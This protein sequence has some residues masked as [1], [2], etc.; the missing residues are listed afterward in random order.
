MGEFLTAVGII[1]GI[2]LA[3]VL[4]IIISTPELMHL[5]FG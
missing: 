2:I 1:G 4:M 3:A 5:I